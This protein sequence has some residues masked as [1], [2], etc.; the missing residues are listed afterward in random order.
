MTDADAAWLAVLG[1]AAHLLE[2]AVA[3]DLCLRRAITR[4]HGH[5]YP[6]GHT[7]GP[8]PCPT[9]INDAHETSPWGA[10]R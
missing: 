9:C 8:Q 7:G 5:S 3:D 6:R 4:A 2:R 1:R 10:T